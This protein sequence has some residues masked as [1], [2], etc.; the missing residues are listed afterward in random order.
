M[1][2]K[3]SAQ[4]RYSEAQLKDGFKRITMWVPAADIARA[5]A[6]GEKLRKAFRK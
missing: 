5:L 6:Y 3:F 4:K 2:T 1:T